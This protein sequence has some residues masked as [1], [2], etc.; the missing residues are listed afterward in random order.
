MDDSSNRL[1]SVLGGREPDLKE[2]VTELEEETK[3]LS[4]VLDTVLTA[5]CE[6][7]EKRA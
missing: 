1:G 3:H 7:R 4:E 6:L 2:R 5:L